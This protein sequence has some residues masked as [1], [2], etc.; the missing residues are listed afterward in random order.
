ML[1]KILKMEDMYLFISALQL[2]SDLNL[3]NIC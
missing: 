2:I 3:F 1:C